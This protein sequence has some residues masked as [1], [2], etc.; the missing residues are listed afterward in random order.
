[1]FD[2][3]RA[4]FATCDAVLVVGSRLRGTD[5]IDW[6]LE[7]PKA[8]YRIDVDSDTRERSYESTIFAR[9]DAAQSL[10]KLRELIGTGRTIDPGFA[11]DIAR[12][13]A[14]LADELERK[15]GDYVPFVRALDEWWP[16]DAIWARD[17]SIANSV[18]ANRFP[19]LISNRS[20][21]HAA[22]GG[23]GQGL[24]MGIGA[25]L[26]APERKTVILAGDGGLM[27]NLGELATLVQENANALVI[28]MN[29]RAYG[30]I[31]HIQHMRYGERY[32]LDELTTPDFALVA[33]SLELP[34][35]RAESVDAF[36]G[37]L[38][39]LGDLNG[40]AML[41]VDMRG[42][43]KLGGSFGESQP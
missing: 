21:V 41:E 36:A 29:N 18:W 32:L 4:F 43:G 9:G 11:A 28:V 8:L 5:T 37:A 24:A 13:R 12:T 3:A 23:I 27:L 33:A 26:G 34:F 35:E 7:L 2:A 30:M 17:I 22:G 31:R 14:E 10:A 40:P 20:N 1:M 42:F 19:A 39:R 25:A 6:K 15:L 16:R 38:R